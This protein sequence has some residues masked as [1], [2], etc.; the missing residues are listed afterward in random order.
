[1]KNPIECPDEGA[2]WSA[3]TSKGIGEYRDRGASIHFACLCP[4]IFLRL[5]T[6]IEVER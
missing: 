3:V 1:M 4:I 6:T 2:G 5:V